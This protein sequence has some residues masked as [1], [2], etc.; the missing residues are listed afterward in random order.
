MAPTTCGRAK[1]GPLLDPDTQVRL[2]KEDVAAKVLDG[3]AIM[4][5]LAQGTYYSLDEV[6]TLV[7]ELI[8][9]EHTLGYIVEVITQ[10][11]EVPLETAEIDVQRLVEEMLEEGIV[12]RDAEKVSQVAAP[13]VS[14]PGVRKLTYQPPEFSIYRDMADLL[15]LEP[16]TPGAAQERFWQEP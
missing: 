2:N 1:G 13:P 10:R 16:P 5:N 4:I 3:E 14:E 9:R 8:E 7:W 15:A 6:G 12:M 11:F